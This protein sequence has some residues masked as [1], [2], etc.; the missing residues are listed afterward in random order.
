MAVGVRRLDRPARIGAVADGEDGTGEQQVEA[1][2]DERRPAQEVGETGLL[3]PALPDRA[4]RD[5]ERGATNFEAH[6]CRRD[7]VGR[8][9]RGRGS[10]ATTLSAPRRRCSTEQEERSRETA[11]ERCVQGLAHPRDR[12][13]GLGQVQPE[14]SD[15]LTAGDIA[16]IDEAVVVALE[17]VMPVL[18][19]DDPMQDGP[20]EHRAPIEDD[21]ADPVRALRTHDGKIALVQQRLH[22]D[23]GGGRV[24]RRAPELGRGEE[25]PQG[26]ESGQ[27]GHESD[28]PQTRRSHRMIPPA[29]MASRV[30]RAARARHVARG[31]TEPPPRSRC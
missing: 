21:L 31:S 12:S 3:G 1:E 7:R 6:R 27:P 8:A 19:H 28:H 5:R 18:D 30:A 20:V 15:Q 25:E 16:G 24:G 29:A 22:A 10:A 13:A 9:G 2:R 17:E 14:C 4:G 26:N 23:A 11:Q